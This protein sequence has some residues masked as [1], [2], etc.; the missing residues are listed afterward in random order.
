MSLPHA[1]GS[2]YS[3]TRDLYKW[4]NALRAGKLLSTE[5][6][7]KMFKPGQKNYGYGWIIEETDGRTWYGHGGGIFG[8]ST[9]I[10][11]AAEG[12]TVIIVL[13]NVENGEAAAVARR[14]REGL[15]K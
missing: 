5:S 2:L 13:S 8:F 12:D 10:L 1:A 14:L 9:M 15:P 11:R 3:T 6:Y 7:A 4:H